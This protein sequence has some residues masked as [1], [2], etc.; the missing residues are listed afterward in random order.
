MATWRSL[1]T[2]LSYRSDGKPLVTNDSYYGPARRAADLWGVNPLL[3]NPTASPPDYHLSAGS[4]AIDAAEDL[5]ALVPNDYD[6]VARPQQSHMD[7]GAFE[8]RVSP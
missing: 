3:K 1:T 8:Y 7:I 4:P 5:P 6:G 2:N